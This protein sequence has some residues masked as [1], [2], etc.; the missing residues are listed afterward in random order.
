[1]DI[2]VVTLFDA[3]DVHVQDAICAVAQNYM[4]VDLAENWWDVSLRHAIPYHDIMVIIHSFSSRSEYNQFLISKTSKNIS[5]F[6]SGLL[7]WAVCRTGA[8]WHLMQ[9]RMRLTA[10]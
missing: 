7:V 4:N 2:N 10:C 8:T 6:S 9:F 3:V 1:M 5:A